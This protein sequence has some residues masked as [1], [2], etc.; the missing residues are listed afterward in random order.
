MLPTSLPPGATFYESFEKATFP[1]DPE[2]SVTTSAETEDAR[3]L[4]GHNMMALNW[5]LSTEHASTGIHS[6]KTPDLTN[7]SDFVNASEYRTA[8]VTLDTD[9]FAARLVPGDLKFSSR[10]SAGLKWYVDGEFV[11]G[12]IVGPSSGNQ[13]WEQWTISLRPGMRKVTWQYG[14]D[15]LSSGGDGVAFLDDVYFVPG[16]IVE[17]TSLSPTTSS[18]TTHMPTYF[19]S[20]LPTL[21]PMEDEIDSP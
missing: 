14:F 9:Y 8:N 12:K 6:I 13:E 19:P 16:G 4:D 5:L 10:D 7:D 2:W 21:N 18:P 20:Y 3:R 15:P 11:G 17:P 1:E